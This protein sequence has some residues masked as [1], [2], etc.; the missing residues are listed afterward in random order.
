MGSSGAKSAAP[1]QCRQRELASE[2]KRGVQVVQ[3][4][5]VCDTFVEVSPL[6]VDVNGRRML[7]Q[8]GSKFSLE[9]PAASNNAGP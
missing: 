8:E 9:R 3:Q 7:T 4:V 1:S 2:G 6:L 5:H